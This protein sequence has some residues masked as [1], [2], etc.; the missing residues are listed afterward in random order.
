MS[1]AGFLQSSGLGLPW[2]LGTYGR[3]EFKK[4]VK[5]VLVRREDI[6]ADMAE[7]IAHRLDGRSQD[8]RDAVRVGRLA[9]TV[10]V[11]RAIELLLTH[12]SRPCG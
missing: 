8:V 10:G 11:N 12:E 7:E 1:R 5:G 4:V 6:S 2:R 3:E 9:P